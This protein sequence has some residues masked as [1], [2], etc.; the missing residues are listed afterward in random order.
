VGV[1]VVLQ[2]EDEGKVFLVSLMEETIVSL[3]ASSSPELTFIL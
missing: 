2:E 1:I 3:Q